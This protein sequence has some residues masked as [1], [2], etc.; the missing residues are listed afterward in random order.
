MVIFQISTTNK[1]KS[2]CEKHEY[3]F[4]EPIEIHIIRY[5][6]NRSIWQP[7]I[8]YTSLLEWICA[9][10]FTVEFSKSKSVVSLSV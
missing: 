1:E 3:I 2:L 6:I 10:N 9:Y 4:R 5:Y 7:L 8:C